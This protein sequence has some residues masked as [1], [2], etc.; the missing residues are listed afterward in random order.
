MYYIRDK[1]RLEPSNDT[2]VMHMH[3]ECTQHALSAY[4][5]THTLCVYGIHTPV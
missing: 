2:A 3:A 1:G 4:L 5:L